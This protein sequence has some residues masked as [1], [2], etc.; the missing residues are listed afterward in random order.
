MRRFCLRILNQN[1]LVS[2]LRTDPQTPFALLSLASMSCP[3][4]SGNSVFCQ[5][6]TFCKAHSGDGIIVCQ[7]SKC[8]ILPNLWNLHQTQAAWKDKSFIHPSNSDKPDVCCDSSRFNSVS[9]KSSDSCVVRIVFHCK[10]SPALSS[11]KQQNKQKK[12][13]PWLHYT[14]HSQF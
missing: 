5:R 1:A 12:I 3:H 8:L 13:K 10:K 4:L 14:R 11:T 9:T 2:I 6:I 7:L